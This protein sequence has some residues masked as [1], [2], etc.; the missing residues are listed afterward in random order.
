[1]LI[2]FVFNLTFFSLSLP[3]LAIKIGLFVP[4][5]MIILFLLVISSMLR[6]AFTDP[7]IIPRASKM[8]IIEYNLMRQEATTR[9]GKE[10]WNL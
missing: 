3:F 10:E 6:A 7:G 2:F 9:A 8:E 1:V 5:I 4:I